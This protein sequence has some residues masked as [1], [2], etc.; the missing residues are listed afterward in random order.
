MWAR[1][2]FPPLSRWNL[3]A[4]VSVGP[5]TDGNQCGASTEIINF[6]RRRRMS[7]RLNVVC[8]LLILAASTGAVRADG[9]SAQD[10]NEGRRQYKIGDQLMGKGK[11]AE[12]AAAFE[13][14]YAASPRAGFLLNI[15]NCHRRL[16]DLS[17]ARQY[18]WRFLDAAPKS[19]PSRPEVLEFLKTIE[20]INAD[21]LTVDTPAAPAPAPAPPVALGLSAPSAVPP[22][23]PEKQLFADNLMVSNAGPSTESRRDAGGRSVFGRWWFWTLVGGAVAAGTGTLLWANSRSGAPACNASLG[24][25]N[26]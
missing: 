22:P 20:Q 18:Y 19:H 25:F 6:C 21:G 9:P 1:L 23:A 8:A 5:C 10:E 26:E 13:S 16:G 15:A 14:G 4:G 24:C 3:W 2:V 7:R 17:K 11:Y 12:A